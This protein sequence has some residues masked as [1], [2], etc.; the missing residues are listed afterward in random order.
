MKDF[1]VETAL[2]FLGVC[3]TISGVTATLFDVPA[4]APRA[5]PPAVVTPEPAPAERREQVSEV[6]SRAMRNLDLARMPRA[7]PRAPAAVAPSTRAA[8]TSLPAV[9][10]PPLAPGAPAALAPASP[11][12]LPI[13]P[14]PT[15]PTLL[16]AVAAL[17]DA[18]K[19]VHEVRTEEDLVA[20]EGRMRAA[21]EQMEAACKS[22]AGP[23]CEGAAQMK[24]LG[25]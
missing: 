8:G 24:D 18:V 19:A 1:L 13:E 7:A 5:A 9:A 21:R 22:G 6:L 10:L 16:S 14:S 11:D 3:A 17:G 25:Y 12:V 23:L 2:P 15:D 4:H 20:A